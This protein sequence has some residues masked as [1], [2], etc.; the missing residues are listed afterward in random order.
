MMSSTKFLKRR[1]VMS[2]LAV[3]FMTVVLIC[4]LWFMPAG[5]A[6]DLT[7]GRVSAFESFGP[8]DVQVHYKSFLGRL[9]PAPDAFVALNGSTVTAWKGAWTASV[10]R[11]IISEEYEYT[12]QYDGSVYAGQPVDISKLH[13]HAVHPNGTSVEVQDFQVKKEIVPMTVKYEMLI[14]VADSQVKWVTDVVVPT[15]LAMVYDP[16]ACTGDVFDK[17]LMGLLLKYPDGSEYVTD[18]FDVEVSSNVMNNNTYV[19]VTSPYGDVSGNLSP[20]NKSLL[21]LRYSAVVNE[22]DYLMDHN[23]EATAVAPDGS[24]IFIHDLELP[25]MGRVKTDLMIPVNTAMGVGYLIVNPVRIKDIIPKV[26]E[27]VIEGM[28]PNIEGIT[29]FYDVGEPKYISNTS[30]SNFKVMTHGTGVKAGHNIVWCV[31]NDMYYA[32]D[33]DAVPISVSDFR[34]IANRSDQVYDLNDEDVNLLAVLAQRVAGDSVKGILYETS[35]M[36]NRY[37]LAT[38]GGLTR[39][40]LMAYIRSSG[41][42]GENVDDILKDYQPTDEARHAVKDVVLKGYRYLKPYVGERTSVN[43][44]LKSSMKKPEPD[45]TQLEIDAGT[46]RYSDI[47][48]DYLYCYTEDAYRRYMREDPV[49]VEWDDVHP[50][51]TDLDVIS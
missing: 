4:Y 41:Y 16:T 1:M 21:D 46:V 37:E 39:E 23:V 14:D 25:N 49:D 11:N 17:N 51:Y 6:I 3:I 19:K 38:P 44:I 5:L 27:E 30:S 8:D 50:G 22:G 31:D 33:V 20:M 48:E 12:V 35:L 2:V 34:Q 9:T 15:E 7:E 47:C 13:V 42:W 28:I 43:N 40:G 29:V 10:E 32:V 24:Q 36:I 45:V 18:D 26:S